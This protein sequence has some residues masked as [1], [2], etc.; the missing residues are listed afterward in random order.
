MAPLTLASGVFCCSSSSA[1]SSCR[2]AFKEIP[3]IT[4]PYVVKRIESFGW[5]PQRPYRVLQGAFGAFDKRVRPLK[6]PRC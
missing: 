1:H 4:S 5:L 3:P 2:K 6:G